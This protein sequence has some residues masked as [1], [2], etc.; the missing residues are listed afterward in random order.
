MQG[1]WSVK[2]TKIEAAGQQLDAA[3][4]HFLKE[5]WVP[6]IQRAGAAEELAV[7][8]SK[9]TAARSYSMISGR[10]MTSLTCV[11]HQKDYVKVSNLFR[12]WVKHANDQQPDE[13][14]DRRLARIWN[15]DAR[16][17]RVWAPAKTG[18]RTAA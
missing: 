18:R 12:D 15:C 10:S 11:A 1:D 5:Q 7:E 3:I 17:H 8:R 13:I 16:L 9:S 6:A 2:V 14:R 4:D